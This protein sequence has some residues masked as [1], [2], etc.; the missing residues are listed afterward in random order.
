MADIVTLPEIT[1]VGDP[2]ALPETSMDWWA[3][4]FAKGYN[5]PTTEP[6]RP[7]L[8]NDE[9]AAFFFQGFNDGAAAANQRIAELEAELAGQPSIGPEIHGQS[10]EEAQRE[11]NEI[12]EGLLHQHM[13]HI[14]VEHTEEGLSTTSDFNIPQIRPLVE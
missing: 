12:L 4:G 2:Q 10:F 13:P 11:F 1:I 8:I 9:L 7:I 14:E 3:D 5:A 6:E